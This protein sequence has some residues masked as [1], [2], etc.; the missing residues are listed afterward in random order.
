MTNISVANYKGLLA[1]QKAFELALLIYD[2]TSHFPNDEK[3]GLTLQLRK[4]G[5]SVPS[6]IAEGEGRKSRGVF[7]NSLYIALGS[8]KEAET[9]ILISG[10]LGY[11]TKN[12]VLKLMELTSEV[13]RLIN[14]LIKSLL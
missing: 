13:G 14:G 12:S 4:A 6:N 10:S 11:L 9:Q 2:E 5:I 7:R 3:Y 8:L 1:W